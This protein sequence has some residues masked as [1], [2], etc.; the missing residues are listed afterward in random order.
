LGEVPQNRHV[1]R[2]SGVRV[3]GALSVGTSPLRADEVVLFI[4]RTA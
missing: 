2:L 3:R 1:E 4:L